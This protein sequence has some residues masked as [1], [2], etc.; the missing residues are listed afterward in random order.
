MGY[1]TGFVR[2]WYDFIIGDDWLVAVV[3][4]L[5]LILLLALNHGP[6]WLLPVIVILVLGASLWRATR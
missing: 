4:L 2:F 6:W 1:V 3:V 5:T